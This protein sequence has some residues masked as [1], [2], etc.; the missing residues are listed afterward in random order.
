MIA[1]RRVKMKS[2]IAALAVLALHA[3]SLAKGTG[4]PPD[5]FV[6]HKH[7]STLRLRYADD[8]LHATCF[9]NNIAQRRLMVGV[10]DYIG[11]LVPT[12]LHAADDLQDS[13]GEQEFSDDKLHLQMPQQMQ[14]SKRV[15]GVGSRKV[16]R[17]NDANIA[18]RV[19]VRV[20]DL[21]GDGNFGKNNDNTNLSGC[22]GKERLSRAVASLIAQRTKEERSKLDSFTSANH[23]HSSIKTN[24]NPRT[25]ASLSVQKYSMNNF[26]EQDEDEDNTSADLIQ[27]TKKIDQKILSA[28]WIK[29]SQR[30]RVNDKTPGAEVHVQ[31]AT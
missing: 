1:C 11:P 9:Q 5:A 14:I 21:V 13:S 12:A 3:T 26:E 24:N 31:H 2:S 16:R 29:S 23:K 25:R 18:D 19:R 6:S 27:L 30:R 22:G 17:S 20:R 10:N 4:M 15:V 8:F 28:N 7:V